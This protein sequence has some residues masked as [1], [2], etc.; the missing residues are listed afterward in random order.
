M[1]VKGV[2][3]YGDRLDRGSP[4]PSFPPGDVGLFKAGNVGPQP[5]G[6]PR[7]H[8]APCRLAPVR[9]CGD[10]SPKHAPS[11][12]NVLGARCLLVQPTDAAMTSSNDLYAT[13]AEPCLQ[14]IGSVLTPRS[15]I[16]VAGPLD[17]GREFYENPQSGVSRVDQET[18]RRV[19]QARM[20]QFVAQLREAQSHPVIDPGLLRVP[21]W[22]SALYG[23]F[24]IAVM[25]QYAR[26]AWFLDGWQYSRGATSEF[27]HCLHRNIPCHD[28]RGVPLEPSQA[29]RLIEEAAR[30]IGVLGH[31]ASRFWAR[32]DALRT[33]EKSAP[34]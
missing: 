21:G 15:A 2:R 8:V 18:I 32:L 30:H 20:A 7:R 22:P 5:N 9:G 31:D 13:V 26:A 16:Y 24:F 6:S 12:R 17:T 19:N 34:C 29:R 33:A 10:D 11:R 27:V 25:E 4:Q 3:E 1:D 23:R 14:V 28:E